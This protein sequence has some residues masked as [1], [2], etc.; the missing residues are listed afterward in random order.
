[1]YIVLYYSFTKE[2]GFRRISPSSTRSSFAARVV[3]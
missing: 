3:L 2:R 1:V